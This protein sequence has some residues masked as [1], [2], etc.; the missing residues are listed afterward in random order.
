MYY[1][2]LLY[3]AVY[4]ALYTACLTRMNCTFYSTDYALVLLRSPKYTKFSRKSSV[5]LTDAGAVRFVGLKFDVLT[6]R[7]R[8]AD[9]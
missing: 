3:S 2:L 7:R 5:S 4:T 6:L 8:N 1:S 9:C